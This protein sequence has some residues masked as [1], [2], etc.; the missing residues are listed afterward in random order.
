MRYEKSIWV[1]ARAALNNESTSAVLIDISFNIRSMCTLVCIG[2]VKYTSPQARA[3]ESSGLSA[4]GLYRV[5]SPCSSTSTSNNNNTIIVLYFFS[6]SL[7][8]PWGER[9]REREK[10]SKS[11]ISICLNSVCVAAVALC[12]N[13]VIREWNDDEKKTGD[14]VRGIGRKIKKK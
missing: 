4:C 2:C 1:H 13:S 6:L 3:F 12:E 10:F 9:K 7:L 14:V 8:L 5:L 11:R